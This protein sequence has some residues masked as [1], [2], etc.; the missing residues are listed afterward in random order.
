MLRS[1]LVAV[2]L[3]AGPM[4][5]PGPAAAEPPRADVVHLTPDEFK[6]LE[7][8]L[9]AGA[10]RCEPGFA[11][12]RAAISLLDKISRLNTSDTSSVTTPAR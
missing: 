5:V 3:A 6:Q 12:A 4:A 8:L 10:R 11:C 1:I 2:A 9:D 7:V